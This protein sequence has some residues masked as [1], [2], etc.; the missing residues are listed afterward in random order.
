MHKE[1]KKRSSENSLSGVLPVFTW[2]PC[3]QCSWWDVHGRHPWA[4]HTLGPCTHTG[5]VLLPCACVALCPLP[6]CPTLAR[7][8]LLGLFALTPLVLC[9]TVCLC[10]ISFTSL[11]SALELGIPSV[12][13]LSDPAVPVTAF[14]CGCPGYG[15]LRD[16]TTCP[17]AAVCAWEGQA[18]KRKDKD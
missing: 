10:S 7:R 6:G 13:V 11:C 2:E 5:R 18:V 12:T 9:E 14:P 15:E 3:L 16:Q 17:C 4:E 8:A 1:E